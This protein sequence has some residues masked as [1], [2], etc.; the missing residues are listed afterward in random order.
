MVF[1]RSEHLARHIRLV[2]QRSY[3]HQSILKQSAPFFFPYLPLAGNTPANAP[4]PVT[5]ESNFLA[6]IISANMPRQFIQTSIRRTRS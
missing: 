5:V 4:S 1:S 3:K 2:R 6:S